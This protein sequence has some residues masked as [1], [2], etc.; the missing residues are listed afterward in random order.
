[1]QARA[2]L[3]AQLPQHTLAVHPRIRR[4]IDNMSR[5]MNRA[6]ATM[7]RLQP[8]AEHHAKAQAFQQR[9]Q[10]TVAKAWNEAQNVQQS[11]AEKEA[12]L[13]TVREQVHRQSF[14]QLRSEIKHDLAQLQAKEHR[15]RDAGF[16]KRA[17]AKHDARTHRAVL[18][19]RYGV[20]LPGT[21]DERLSGA[22]PLGDF[23]W[24]RN[25]AERQAHIHQ[26]ADET[27]SQLHDEVE[28]LQEQARR[29][30][31]RAESLQSAWDTN[32]GPVPSIEGKGSYKDYLEA[33][34]RYAL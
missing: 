24:L 4:Y 9:H 18:E 25:A 11:M 28:Q 26:P 7:D 13:A 31:E 30:T 21:D 15:A 17:K 8:L 34:R 19:D 23:D 20:A 14:S 27:V 12:E 32:V 1:D 5:S 2:D 6:E 10:T 16:F 3:A 29:A 33:Q 22:D